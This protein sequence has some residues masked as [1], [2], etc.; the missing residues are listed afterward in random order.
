MKILI[1]EDEMIIA[2]D[3]KSRLEEMGHNV[4][5][6]LNNGKDVLDKMNFLQPGLILMD[7]RIKGNMD[8][9]ELTKQIHDCFDTPVIFMT[10]F[11]DSDTAERIDNTNYYGFMTKPINMFKLS[12]MIENIE[13][14]YCDE[15]RN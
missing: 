15:A 3:M 11:N 8:G 5:D 9:I 14:S 6:I 13:N 10:A 12:D 1:V 7:I 4:V 2:M